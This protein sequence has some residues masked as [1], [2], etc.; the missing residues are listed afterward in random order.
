MWRL[1]DNLGESHIFFKH[2]GP[3]YQ[4]LFIRLHSWYHCILSSH[5]SRI[6]S[7]LGLSHM[8]MQSKDMDSLHDIISL[9]WRLNSET[10][11]TDLE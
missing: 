8:Q 2:V 4:T 11:S 1:E 10:P 3:S 9:N 6:S 5:Y 7:S